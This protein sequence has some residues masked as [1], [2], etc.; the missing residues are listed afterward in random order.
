[1]HLIIAIVQSVDAGLACSRLIKNDFRVT[2]IRTVG[3]F[4]SLGN[5]TLLVGAED[6]RVH[7]AIET[8]HGCCHTR[9]Q[10][11]ST[12]MAAAD[13]FPVH[14][15]LEVEVGGATI[16]V[17]PV[18]RFARLRGGT[19]PA[20]A[21]QEHPR[22]RMEETAVMKLII[23]VIQRELVDKITD[24]LLK[25]GHRVTRIDSVGGFL[26][27]GSGTLV[28]GVE[29][30]KVDEVLR[31]MQENCPLRPEPSPPGK[32]MPMYNATVFVLDAPVFLR[33]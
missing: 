30:A 29:A 3:S 25:G 24:A 20:A 7:E 21:D 19:A 6:E 11:I 12:A 2:R 22:S 15:A 9:R 16:F 23:A 1:M 28:I 32:G 31:L 14:T 4:L 5:E 10:F 26:R 17:L 27:R 13:A 18:Q 8:I 33:V